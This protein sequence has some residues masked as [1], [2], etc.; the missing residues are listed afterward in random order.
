MVV[1]IDARICLLEHRGWARYAREYISALSSLNN[2]RIQVLVPASPKT[3]LWFET[4]KPPHK[5]I[6][7]PFSPVSPDRYWHDDSC[8]PENWLG[9]VDLLHSLCR[10]V[11]PTTLRPVLA[12]VHDIVPLATPPFK[13]EYRE[14]T[15]KALKILQQSYCWITAVSYQTRMELVRFGRIDSR[16][17]RV[18]YEGV[19]ENFREKYDPQIRER[20]LPV[21][22]GC[23]YF[24]CV[25][26]AGENKN[27]HNLIVAFE[28]VYQQSG[29]KL[30]MVGHQSWGYTDI[31]VDNDL[32]DWLLFVGYVTDE[33]LCS[34]YQG[35]YAL[36]LP[37]FHEGFGLPIIEAMALSVP[38]ICSNI[39][40]FREVAA[41]SALFFDPNNTKEISQ[42]IL[43]LLKDKGLR[44]R[45]V[46][47]GLER[48]KLFSWDQT[49]YSTMAYYKFIRTQYLFSRTGDTK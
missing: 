15:I 4:I 30:V 14:A 34:L 31:F 18:I 24:I 8:Y 6:A 25:G 36:V 39:P 7:V 29:A 27:L 3:D 46:K 11:P 10:F 19:S 12:T 33:E 45:L 47:F 43:Y 20:V 42:S 16:R 35:A 41:E 38:V 13:L 28:D 23:V 37:S 22:S 9:S 40:V 32:P 44:R 26:G 48:S 2:I 49:A 21:L 17:I 5:V 1:G